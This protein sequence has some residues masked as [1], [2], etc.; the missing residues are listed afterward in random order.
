MRGKRKQYKADFKA[1]V[2]LAAIKAER[3]INELAAHYEVYPNQITKWKKQALAALPEVF[4]GKI[5]SARRMTHW[6]HDLGCG[7]DE[8]RVR[9]LLR[10]MGLEAI[11]PMPKLSEGG[12]EHRKFPYL[13]RG[14][15]IRRPNQVWAADITYLR[16]R[17]GFAYLVAIMDWYSR[18]V[19]S[20]TC[21]TRWRLTSVRRYWRRR[22]AWAPQRSR[23][24]TRGLSSQ[25]RTTSGSWS[26]PGSG[27]VWTGGAGSSTTSWWNGCGGP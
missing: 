18:Y 20:W 16:L 23:T 4:S 24:R 26:V 13:L 2:A 25:A 19:L 12:P 11:Y 3:T 10:L 8:K 15:A 17:H 1:R 7:V 14:L 9:R 22:C 27:S 5:Q 6:L 21:R